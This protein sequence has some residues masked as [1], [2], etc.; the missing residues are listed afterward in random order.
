MSVSCNKEFW[1][2]LAPDLTACGYRMRKAQ[3]FSI[4]STCV[5]V[6]VF[7]LTSWK[8]NGQ[9]LMIF[10]KMSPRTHHNYL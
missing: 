9:G 2:Q 10:H 3:A 5:G 6:L 7:F 8:L 1:H 4:Y